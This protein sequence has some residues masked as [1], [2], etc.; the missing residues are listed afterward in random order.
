MKPKLSLDKKTIMALN[1]V[2]ANQVKG[3]GTWRSVCVLVSCLTCKPC[4]M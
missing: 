2:S 4:Q 1:P 3:G